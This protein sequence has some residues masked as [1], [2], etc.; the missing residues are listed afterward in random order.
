M[1]ATAAIGSSADIANEMDI[2]RKPNEQPDR[3]SPSTRQPGRSPRRPWGIDEHPEAAIEPPLRPEFTPADG[4]ELGVRRR[5]RRQLVERRQ[6][7]ELSTADRK[8]HPISRHRIDE[9]GRVTG[10]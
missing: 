10:E 5:P 4:P 6:C 7:G 3:R 8:P 1:S 9:S 2:A